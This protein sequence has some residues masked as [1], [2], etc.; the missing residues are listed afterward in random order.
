MDRRLDVL[1]FEDTRFWLNELFPDHYEAQI[2]TGFIRTGSAAR[3]SEDFLRLMELLGGWDGGKVFYT[4]SS[5]AASHLDSMLFLFEEGRLLG[6][7]GPNEQ[8]LNGG[9]TWYQDTLD[10]WNQVV[11][12]VE[13]TILP[14]MDGRPF[15]MAA[16]SVVF[17]L[18]AGFVPSFAGNTINLHYYTNEGAAPSVLAQ[19]RKWQTAREFLFANDGQIVGRFMSEVGWRADQV[20]DVLQSSYLESALLHME[21]IVAPGG[22]NISG[23]VPLFCPFKLWDDPEDVV[24]S[25]RWGLISRE[26]TPRPSFYMLQAAARARLNN[27]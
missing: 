16:P 25:R 1:R 22:V 17:H 8:N 11:A 14:Q 24:P 3:N 18:L 7:E 4:M 13:K 19:S 9:P 21:Q 5:A 2:P 20:T 10:T 26:G 15:F 27:F 23:Q 6:V 12:E